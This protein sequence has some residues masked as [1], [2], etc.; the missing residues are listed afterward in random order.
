MGQKPVEGPHLPILCWRE[1]SLGA[2][3]SVCACAC[4]CPCVCVYDC[5]SMCVCAF[6][7]TKV[8]QLREKRVT[9]IIRELGWGQSQERKEGG[10]PGRD[11]TLTE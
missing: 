7:R 5:V 3:W 10:G 9:V 4:V 2:S 11:R 8:S 1:T 6:G